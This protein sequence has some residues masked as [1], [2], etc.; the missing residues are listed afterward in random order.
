MSLKHKWI[1]LR[2]LAW[3]HLGF[4]VVMWLGFSG[5]R[6]LVVVDSCS[7]RIWYLDGFLCLVTRK[8]EEKKRKWIRDYFVLDVFVWLVGKKVKGKK[9]IKRI[10]FFFFW[11]NWGINFVLFLCFSNFYIFLGKVAF[12]FVHY[13]F[14]I[15]FYKPH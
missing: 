6:W 10:F 15:L 9:K 3:D 13:N 7:W 8:V 11:F 14:L 12:F 2:F 1:D 5:C 4:V